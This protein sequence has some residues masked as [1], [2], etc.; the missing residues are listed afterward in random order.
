M[1]VLSLKQP[2]ATLVCIGAKK[3]ETRSFET[4]Y[5]GKILI[6]A[7]KAMPAEYKKL[8]TTSKPFVNALKG[9]EE[10]QLGKIIGMVT[11]NGIIKTE[12]VDEF[13][14]ED[15]H[16]RWYDPKIKN[17]HARNEDWG[18]RLEIEKAFGDYSLGRFGWDLLEP[19]MFTNFTQFTG[20]LGFTKEFEDR[21]CCMCGC[22]EMNCPACVEKLGHGCSWVNHKKGNELFLCSACVQ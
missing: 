2:Y 7:S 15:E 3:I 20:G 6:H 14:Y 18:R 12:D 9:I 8:A 21:I 17:E 13:T 1:K 4:S 5:H 10:L 11:I 19:V 22:T 16:L